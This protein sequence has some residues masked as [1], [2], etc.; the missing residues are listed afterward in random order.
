MG[1]Y[2]LVGAG[3]I[4]AALFV[5]NNLSKTIFR[6]TQIGFLDIL[7][8]FMTVLIPL[9]ALIMANLSDTPDSRIANAALLIGG[10]LAVFSLLIAILEL[11]RPQR[12]KGSRGILGLYSGLLLGLA[13]FLVP[14]MAIYFSVRAEVRNA[15]ATPIVQVAESTADTTGTEEVSAARQERA[16][17]MFQAIKQVV[18]DEIEIDDD[19]LTSALQ[20]G[21]PLAQLV[22]ERGGN[23]EHVISGI[24]AVMQQSV[25]EA[26]AAGDINALQAAFAISQMPNFIRIAVNSDLNTLMQ[27]FGGGTPDPNA[28]RAPLVAGVTA[29]ATQ[30][31]TQ[32]QTASAA[33][34]ATFTM[35]ATNTPRATATAS[36]TRF[37]YHTR[38]PTFTATPVTPCLASVE[39]NLRLRSAPNHNSETLLVIPY[40]TT[41]ELYGHGGASENG[42]TWWYA[43]YEG[44]EGW[45]DGQ[46]ML[47]SS[48]C[49][50]LPE[51]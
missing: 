34:T 8:V 14:F 50:R 13:A 41:V 46:F 47:V 51:R 6:R 16:A 48:G 28:T 10:G 29:S 9:V 19:T 4:F 39:Y 3:V 12:L 26:A 27:R 49:D 2:L 37:E 24:T 40:S 17:K 23:V 45:L 35:P 20:Q 15:T 31:P 25:R 33:P 43:I 32:M 21:T 36:A 38:T 5:L 22:T 30:T 44:Q 11:F 18:T 1:I 42:G 7:L